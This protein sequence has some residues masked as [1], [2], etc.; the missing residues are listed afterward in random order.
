MKIKKIKKGQSANLP[1]LAIGGK[2]GWA[3]SRAPEDGLI[4]SL[5]A[6][7]ASSKGAFVPMPVLVSMGM[8]F[9]RDANKRAR[10]LI[11]TFTLD[12]LIQ[13]SDALGLPKTG[14]K[15]KLARRISRVL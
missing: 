9:V 12:G 11:E 10:L 15:A 3:W 13:L 7:E 4:I 8:F 5:N 6:S 1:C 2:E 14:N